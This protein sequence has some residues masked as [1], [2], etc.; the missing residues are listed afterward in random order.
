MPQLQALNTQVN[1][2]D[3]LTHLYT[4]LSQESQLD[5]TNNNDRVR[6][7]VR[8]RVTGNGEVDPAMASRVE[9]GLSLKSNRVNR[10]SKF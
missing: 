8:V 5:N 9:I 10:V 1:P 2:R 7:C 6:V 4:L 3:C